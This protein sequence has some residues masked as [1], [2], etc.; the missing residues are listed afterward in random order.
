MKPHWFENVRNEYRAC[1]ESVALADYSS[2][3]KLDLTSSSSSDGLEVSDFLQ[4][5]CSNDVDVPVGAIV[6]AC[7]SNYLLFIKLI[8]PFYK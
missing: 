7:F 2:F 3:T 4:Y 1:R 8:L 5:V 6:S